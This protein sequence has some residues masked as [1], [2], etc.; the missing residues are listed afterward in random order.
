MAMPDK[1]VKKKSGA[2][3]RLKAGKKKPLAKGL[4]KQKRSAPTSLS[5]SASKKP[6][7]TAKKPRVT[8]GQ[9]FVS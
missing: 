6:C 4:Q 9:L 3:R 2:G 5:V 1:A 8:L 7:L